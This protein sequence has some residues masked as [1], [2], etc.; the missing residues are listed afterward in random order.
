LS[1]IVYTCLR[2]MLP[3]IREEHPSDVVVDITTSC[4]CESNLQT[5]G[6]VDGRRAG[7]R[8][9]TRKHGYRQRDRRGGLRGPY[10]DGGAEK[11]RVT[12][13]DRKR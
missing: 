13:A 10:P 2:H 1:V 7:H 11:L 6:G 9:R 4:I 5:N 3:G 12:Y 8:L